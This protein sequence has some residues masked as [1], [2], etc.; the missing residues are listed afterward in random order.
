M[1]EAALFYYYFVY[2]PVTLKPE[3]SLK[4]TRNEQ[5]KGKQEL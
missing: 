1:N 4:A 3:K 5:L 2:V